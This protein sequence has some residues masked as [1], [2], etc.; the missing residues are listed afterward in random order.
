[1][2][3]TV[4]NC[5][6]HRLFLIEEFLPEQVSQAF[7]TFA[8]QGRNDFQL[9]SRRSSDPEYRN[10]GTLT[11][12]KPFGK[13][14]QTALALAWRDILLSLA[15]ESFIPENYGLR[16]TMLRPGA[17]RKPRVDARHASVASRL[18]L[19]YV[20]GSAPKRYDGGDLRFFEFDPYHSYDLKVRRHLDISATP[21]SLFLFSSDL[22]YELHEVSAGV[23]GP[24]NACFILDGNIS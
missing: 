4:L 24:S 18:S 21:N 19:I 15:I 17:Y 13:I 23:F 5:G 10:I 1:M 20:L 22:P 16:I 14:F 3:R 6:R 8:I 11:E 9:S 12:I 2:N 7:L